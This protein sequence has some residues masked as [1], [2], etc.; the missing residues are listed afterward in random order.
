[1]AELDI[2]IIRRLL[3][4]R[5]PMLLVDRVLDWEA[6]NFVRA[7][8]NVTINEPF[9]QGHFPAYPV[10]PGVL[11]IEAMA[12]VAGLL[13]MLSDVARRDGT[14]LVLFAGIDE[15]RF[16]RQVVPGD[17]LLLEAYL[18]RAVRGIGRFRTKATVGEGL[19]CEAKLLA[20]IRDVPPTPPM[21]V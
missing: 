6:G 21:P 10:M 9:F 1:M 17:T 13:T 14:Q 16:K 5:Y 19:V 7:V 2:G 15:A 4:H 11:V 8:K 18:E 12:Q 3:P 20:A